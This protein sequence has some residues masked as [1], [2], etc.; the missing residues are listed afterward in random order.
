VKIE[1]ST[2]GDIGPA[3]LQ[4][5]RAEAKPCLRC[6]MLATVDP[7]THAS[8][9]GHAPVIADGA[10]RLA[11][12]MDAL[13]WVADE[14][15]PEPEPEPWSCPCYSCD[16]Q[17]GCDTPDPNY[18]L[19]HRGPMCRACAGKADVTDDH[20]TGVQATISQDR[21]RLVVDTWGW[22]NSSAWLDIED[23]DALVAVL[24]VRRTELAR[25]RQEYK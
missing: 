23:V 21:V 4:A 19:T 5:L 7:I 6:G 9:Y 15:E 12:S 3:E 22:P 14:P 10:G 25:E 20:L 8:R 16:G 18:K 1:N 13:S 17:C 11:W 2:W 24:L